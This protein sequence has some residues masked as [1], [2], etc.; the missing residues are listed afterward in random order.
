MYFRFASSGKLVFLLFSRISEFTLIGAVNAIA[1]KRMS[2]MVTEEK[3]RQTLQASILESEIIHSSRATNN[4]Y[5][6]F[7]SCAGRLK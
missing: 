1:D 4:K 6:I 3:Y 5:S 7:T 2:A